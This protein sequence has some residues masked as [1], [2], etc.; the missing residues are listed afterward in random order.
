[1]RRA[2]AL[3][4]SALFTLLIALPA[5]AAR[6]LWETTSQYYDAYRVDFQINDPRIER[7]TASAIVREGADATI[8]LATADAG[9]GDS[10]GN[11]KVNFSVVSDEALS[12]NMSRP[13][14]L[15][16]AKI[17]EYSAG[18]WREIA[19][20]AL[21]VAADAGVPATQRVVSAGGA[22]QFD[23]SAKATLVPQDQLAVQCAAVSGKA[24][25]QV[26]L[27]SMLAKLDKKNVAAN[28][29]L[30][31]CCCTASCRNNP[32]QS[33][34]CC[35]VICCSEGTSCQASCCSPP[36]CTGGS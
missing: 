29:N 8:T 35:N 4:L 34:W 20:P 27:K 10:D 15:I 36:N 11:I 13:I 12:K 16:E 30:V 28:A 26:D 22:S 6:P 21:T 32:S 24:A 9:Q 31:P 33:L 7:R 3:F 2:P 14:A 25:K 23:F 17:S 1:M 5:T 19:S 18:A